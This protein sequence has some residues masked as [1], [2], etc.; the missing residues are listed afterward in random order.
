MDDQRALSDATFDLIETEA[1][2]RGHP[3]FRHLSRGV[4]LGQLVRG[5]STQHSSLQLADLISGAGFSVAQRHN[6]LANRAGEDLYSVVVTLIDAAGMLPH[7][8]PARVARPA[9]PAA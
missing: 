3:E 1:R 9:S 2:D 8:E 4:H 7:D 6:G 5:Q